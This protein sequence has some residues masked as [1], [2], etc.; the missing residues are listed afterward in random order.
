[1]AISA[2]PMIGKPAART[3]PLPMAVGLIGLSAPQR[4]RLG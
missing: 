2:R 1:M 3:K 4:F